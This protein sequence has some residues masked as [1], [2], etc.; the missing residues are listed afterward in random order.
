MTKEKGRFCSP[1]VLRYLSEEYLP[2]LL[3]VAI[4]YIYLET[5]KQSGGV[6]AQD[7]DPRI[8]KTEVTLVQW[9]HG[10]P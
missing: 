9:G 7:P 8:L 6:R 4:T 2:Y 10:E 3:K 5:K 1:V